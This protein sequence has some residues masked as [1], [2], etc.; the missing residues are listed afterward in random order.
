MCGRG[1]AAVLSVFACIFVAIAAC[2]SARAADPADSAIMVAG[3]RHVGADAIRS[4]FHT[5]AEGRFD[6]EALNAGLKSLYATGLFQNV[7]ISRD[8]GRVVVQ[9][10]ENPT[11]RHLA[12]EGNKK[13]KDDD[14]K[15]G[16]QSKENGPLSPAFVQ[17]DVTQIIAQYRQH[18]YFDV[19][20]DPKTIKINDARVNLVFEIKEG[21]KL[22]VRKILFAGNSAFAANKLN[23]VDQ[24]RSNEFFELSAR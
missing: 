15:K 19:R 12:F 1:L 8:D 20:V 24:D 4:Y 18:G 2:G 16:L 10:I 5:G 9:V 11:I 23:G 6:E 3:N 13:I 17:G 7:K 14:L 22:A 21:D